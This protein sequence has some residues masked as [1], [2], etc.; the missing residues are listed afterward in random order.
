MTD[1]RAGGQFPPPVCAF[2]VGPLVARGPAGPSVL[3]L[4]RAWCDAE[5]I[6]A[7]ADERL[8]PQRL[9]LQLGAP[10]DRRGPGCRSS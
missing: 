6:G 3:K 8:V 10:R 1:G 9:P 7:T 4:Q 5:E 2:R